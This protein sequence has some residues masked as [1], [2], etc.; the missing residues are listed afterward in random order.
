MKNVIPSDNAICFAF[1]EQIPIIRHLNQE[2]I[3]AGRPSISAWTFKEAKTGWERLNFHLPNINA[4][5][6]HY[7]ESG[8]DILTTYDIVCALSYGDGISSTSNFVLDC[9]ND[10]WKYMSKIFKYDDVGS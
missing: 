1:Q 7:R 5:L 4:L 6:K 3:D 9:L 8:Y 10:F 2:Q